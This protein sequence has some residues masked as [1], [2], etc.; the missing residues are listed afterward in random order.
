MFLS[1]SD[2]KNNETTFAAFSL[3]TFFYLLIAHS[4][5]QS[6]VS[7]APVRRDGRGADNEF[8]GV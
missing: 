4:G 5:H 2:K 1:H 6:R 3:K 8:R 7:S